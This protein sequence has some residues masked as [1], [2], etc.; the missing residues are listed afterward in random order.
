MARVFFMTKI[1]ITFALL[2]SFSVFSYAFDLFGS[3]DD[4]EKVE[5]T[6]DKNPGQNISTERFGDW[7]VICDR[8]TNQCN[9]SISLVNEDKLEVLSVRVIPTSN[10][11]VVFIIKSPLG[12][13]IR[14]GIQIIITNKLFQI[15]YD[16]CDVGGCVSSIKS[17]KEILTLLRKED[18]ATFRF[19]NSRNV[20]VDIPISLKGFSKALRKIL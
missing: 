12:V 1:F 6:F 10:N 11:E 5:T 8:A 7:T 9:S 16:T 13:K 18:I 20:K 3:N 14:H 15:P 4:D 19:H 17:S 2:I